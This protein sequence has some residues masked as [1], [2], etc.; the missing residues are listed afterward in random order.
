MSRFI[1]PDFALIFDRLNGVISSYV[2]GGVTL[3]ERGP[4]PDFWRAAT[5]ND[6]GAWKSLV[7]QARKD[8]ALDIKVWRHAGPSWKVMEA[9]VARI[10]G[11]TGSVTVRAELPAVGAAYTMAYIISGSGEVRVT[12]TYTPGPRPLAMM[13]R[14]GMELIV[15][16]GLDRITWYGRGP[17]ETHVDRAFEPIGVYR[18]TVQEQWVEYSRPQENGNKTDVRW[19]ELRNARGVGLRA[20]GDVPLSV[21]AR[22]ATKDDMERATYSFELPRRSEIYLNL[23][24]KQMGVGGIDSWSRLA[25]PM[26][27]YRIPPDRTYSYSYRLRPVSGGDR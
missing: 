24:W 5:D 3:L 14:F 13:P 12:G 16:P 27:P 9:A 8:P 15:A 21:A 23:D 10:D 1:G 22:H 26:E 7:S 17:A 19:V 11:S 4:V 6:V 18:S 20:E 2:H 25:Y